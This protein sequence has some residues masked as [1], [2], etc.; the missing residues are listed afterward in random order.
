MSNKENLKSKI[1]DNTPAITNVINNHQY[2]VKVSGTSSSQII[3]VPSGSSANANAFEISHYTNLDSFKNHHMQ[4]SFYNGEGE[5]EDSLTL[6]LWYHDNDIVYKVGVPDSYTDEEGVLSN[7]IN[8]YLNLII[9]ENGKPSTH[10]IDYEAI[11]SHAT[12]FK[13]KHLSSISGFGTSVSLRCTSDSSADSFLMNPTS[14]APESAVRCV[15]KLIEITWPN[16][17]T[18]LS[19]RPQ[20]EYAEEVRSLIRPAF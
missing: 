14:P 9:D 6:Y 12:D 11:S 2:D 1:T 20:R 8:G 4:V 15:L 10:D 17:E 5:V 13:N 18:P 19:V 3:D 7:N 16:A